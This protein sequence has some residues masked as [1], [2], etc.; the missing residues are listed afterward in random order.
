MKS[1][2]VHRGALALLL[3]SS[4]ALAANQPSVFHFHRDIRIESGQSSGDVSCVGCSVYV[5]GQVMGD[6]AVVFGSLVLSPSASVK[7]DVA[8][9]GGNLA[10]EQDRSI[11]GDVAVL[12][13]A[14][15]RSSDVHVGGEIAAMQGRG[16]LMLIVVAPFLGLV[17]AAA[18]IIW[19]VQRVR[20][21]P[22][23]PGP[24]Y[25]QRA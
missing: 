10:A 13:G 2:I 1:F 18:L 17:L 5:D 16:W 23:S 22:R 4:A 9:I 6:V 12:G 11:G 8:V 19:I 25:N 20:R 3:V 15:H 21:R 24:A 7:G 14:F